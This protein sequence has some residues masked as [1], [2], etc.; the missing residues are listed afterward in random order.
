MSYSIFNITA[1]IG[2][3]FV[4]GPLSSEQAAI[5]EV[6]AHGLVGNTYDIRTP[7]QDNGLRFT[8]RA[9]REPVVDLT[10]ASEEKSLEPK[11]KQGGRTDAWRSDHHRNRQRTSVPV[12]RPAVGTAA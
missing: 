6:R 3:R 1:N 7:L 11:R 2:G 9:E 10:V 8:I 4:K 12:L 5:D